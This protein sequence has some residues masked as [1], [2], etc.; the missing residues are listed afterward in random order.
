MIAEGAE[1]ASGKTVELACPAVPEPAPSGSDVQVKRLADMS[2]TIPGGEVY[3]LHQVDVYDI[4]SSELRLEGE[5]AYLDYTTKGGEHV[6]TLE[7]ERAIAQQAAQEKPAEAAEAA[8]AA[9]AAEQA[10]ASDENYAYDEGYDSGYA[11]DYDYGY[12]SGY[13]YNGGGGGG[14]VD[15]SAVGSGDEAACIP[16]IVLR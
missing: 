3:E 4:A 7:S 12:N 10:P 2:V 13:D 16:D 1:I 6:S 11:N 14:S 8:P 9:P 15:D 5:I